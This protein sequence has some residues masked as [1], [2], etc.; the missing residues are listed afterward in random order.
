[1]FSYSFFP[2]GRFSRVLGLV[3]LVAATATAS[4]P[5]SGFVDVPPDG[6]MTSADGVVTLTW[7]E[8]P[9]PWEVELQQSENPD[10]ATV[11]E[12]YAG[13]DTGSVLTGLPEGAHHFRLRVVHT[14]GTVGP[15]SDP[16][17]VEVTF[18]DRGQLFLLLGLGGIVVL[19]TAG[20]IVGGYLNHRREIKA[21]GEA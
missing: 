19:A 12:R 10:F 20:A 17:H 18:M 5:E 13:R 1:M 9:A 14:D 2:V 21:E 6:R 7:R 15:W 16:V 3:A 8:L 4:V 11:V